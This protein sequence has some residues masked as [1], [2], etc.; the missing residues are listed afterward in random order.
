[1]KI[2]RTLTNFVRINFFRTLEITKDYRECLFNKY[3]WISVKTASFVV[4]LFSLLPSTLSQFHKA[5]K[6]TACNHSEKSPA[7]RR[8]RTLLV[9]SGGSLKNSSMKLSLFGWLWAHPMQTA[10]FVFHW[11]AF[12]E[13]QSQATVKHCDCLSWWTIFGGK[14]RII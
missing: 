6:P 14:N 11:G 12:R 10:C 5:M 2:T 1:M 3:G 8:N 7:N 4:F 9:M 13:K